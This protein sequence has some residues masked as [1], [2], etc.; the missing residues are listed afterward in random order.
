MDSEVP[1]TDRKTLTGAELEKGG[2]MKFSCRSCR[3]V[4]P[5]RCPKHRKLPSQRKTRGANKPRP[6]GRA[7][8]PVVRDI[9][10]A[11]KPLLRYTPP[12]EMLEAEIVQ[13]L[14]AT[15]S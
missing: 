15:R 12:Y 10:K 4:F 1:M 8:D 7:V 5:A 9:L 11:R 13:T 6:T 2:F 3:D 14:R